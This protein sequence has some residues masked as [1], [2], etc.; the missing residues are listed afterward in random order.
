MIQPGQGSRLSREPFCESRVGRS[1]WRE[2]LHRHEPVQA[3]LP[4]LVN[5]THA[6]LA[7][8]FQDF[9]LRK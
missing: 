1:L 5:G 3:G 2:Y 9:E 7:N 4:R 6:A 8:E